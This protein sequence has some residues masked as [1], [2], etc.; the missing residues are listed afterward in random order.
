MIPIDRVL[1]SDTWIAKRCKPPTR[2]RAAGF[3]TVLY[4]IEEIFTLKGERT[5]L[6][7]FM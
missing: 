7:K 6:Y 5:R 2:F 4:V 3:A 1:D